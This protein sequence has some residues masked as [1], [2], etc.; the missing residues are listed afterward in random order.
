MRELQELEEEEA[1]DTAQLSLMERAKVATHQLIQRWGFWA[2]LAAASI[3][4]PVCA[5]HDILLCQQTRHPLT[6]MMMAHSRCDQLFDLAGVTCGHFLI[7]FWTFFSATAIGKGVIKVSL[8]SMFY[9]VA[10]SPKNLEVLRTAVS[11]E[12]WQNALAKVHDG[13]DGV[14]MVCVLTCVGMRSTLC[15]TGD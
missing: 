10:L 5:W 9:I 12:P 1:G 13:P 2:I 3:P 4:N 14:V 8:Q 7:P 6:V 15:C 11:W